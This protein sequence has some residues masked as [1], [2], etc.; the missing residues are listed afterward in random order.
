MSIEERIKFAEK[1]R[2]EAFNIGLL[3]DL[4]YWNGY[5]DALHEVSEMTEEKDD[6]QR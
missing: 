1:Q 4:M 6:E 3:A 2:D 5:I